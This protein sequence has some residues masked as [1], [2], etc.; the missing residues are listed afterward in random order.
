MNGLTDPKTFYRSVVLLCTDIQQE[1]RK[2]LS[3]VPENEWAV[4]LDEVI[5]RYQYLKKTVECVKGI[6]ETGM[7]R[8]HDVIGGT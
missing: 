3:M 4:F 7:T 1:I 6:A 2:H 5:R 8:M